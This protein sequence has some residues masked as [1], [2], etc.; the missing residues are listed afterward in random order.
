MAILF[1]SFGAKSL[2]SG[3]K[4]VH[5]INENPN[6]FQEEKLFFPNLYKLHNL[7]ILMNFYLVF[8]RGVPL[9]LMAVV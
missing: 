8:L 1:V 6:S 9:D 3:Q 2:A 4:F 7:Y 5:D